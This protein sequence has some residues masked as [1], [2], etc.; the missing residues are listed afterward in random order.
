MLRW[1]L[2]EIQ[3]TIYDLY[4]DGND[5]ITTM[6]IS[7]QLG[8]SF[9]LAVISTEICLR[10]N[11]AVVK[12]VIPQKNQIKSILTKNMKVILQ[13]CP[14]DIKPEWKENDKVWRFPNGSE[15]Q[16][17]GT[18]N[19]SYDSIRGGTC[20]GWMV[21]EA[22]F[23]SDLKEVVY[24]VL[25][26]TTTMT[27]GRGILSST[28]NPKQPEHPFVSMFVNMALEQGKLHKYT[29]DDNPRLS[30]Q[31]IM[32]IENIYPGGR[33]NPEFRA[34]YMCE[35]IRDEGSMVLPEFN[36]EAEAASV[37]SKID[38]PEYFDTYVSMDIGGKDFTVLLF[39]Y[40]DF[41]RNKV[42][43]ED[44]IVFKEKQNTNNIGKS[45]Q[46]KLAELWRE[47]P[48]YMM[49]ADN[50]NIILLND[51][52]YSHN[53]NFI[54]TK[55]DNKEAQINTVRGMIQANRIEIHERCKTLIYHMKTAMWAKG[56]NKGYKQFARGA[57]QGHFD[58]VDALIYFIRNV[59]YSKNPFPSNYGLLSGQNSHTRQ[60][61]DSSY[62]DIFKL[63][64]V[65]KTK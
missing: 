42:V 8:K 47:K 30:R 38:R 37:I 63:F 39:G 27:K 40:Y 57:D 16:V 33:I 51:L 52:Q 12:Y 14:A 35:I 41:M 60:K 56:A 5:A 3:K 50:N 59:I 46:K 43:I 54:P 10:K 31:D 22:G 11:N 19:Q 24:S 49:T 9:A 62:A 58:A 1:K 21:D 29:I 18:D 6:L 2:H 15:I 34:E 25:I 53:L 23:C 36:D 55:K 44:E 13:D 26:P 64:K 20:D 48:P 65:K 61:P 32:D 4:W 7:R 17:A 45:I 28:P